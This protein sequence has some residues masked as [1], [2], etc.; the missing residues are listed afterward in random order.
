MK[1]SAI[2]RLNS[3]AQSSQY[4]LIIVN[5][6]HDRCLNDGRAGTDPNPEQA[7]VWF[8]RCADMYEHPQAQYELGVALY[9]GEGVV[10]NEE[11]A[12]KWFRLASE[13]NHPAACY[14]L[15]DCLL[16]GS[17]VEIDRGAALEW[18]IRSSELGHR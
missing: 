3:I 18:L 17:G 16:D 2:G 4:I 9:T 8:R 6:N 5:E 13:Q 12:I 7:V 15:G 1:L 10:E 14:M 11:E